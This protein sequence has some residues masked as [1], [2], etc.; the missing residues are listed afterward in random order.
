VR[1]AADPEP[2]ASPTKAQLGQV[3]ANRSRLGRDMRR[4]AQ[5]RAGIIKADFVWNEKRISKTR[6]VEKREKSNQPTRKVS[7]GRTIKLGE[8]IIKFKTCTLL[9]VCW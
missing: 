2:E 3:C 5:K 7:K 9:W 8:T 4:I 1:V 6:K